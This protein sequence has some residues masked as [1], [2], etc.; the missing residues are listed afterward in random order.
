M[1]EKIGPAE[2]VPAFIEKV[3]RREEVL[4]G[5]GHRIYKLVPPLR[6]LYNVNDVLDR[7]SDPRSF[8]VREIAD[9]VFGVTGTDPLL[10]TAMALKDAALADDYFKSR[11]LYPNVD[12]WSGLSEWNS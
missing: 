2:N 6:P 5:F 1:L 9:E 10:E 11:K 7:T 3:K 12:F 8:I 4:S